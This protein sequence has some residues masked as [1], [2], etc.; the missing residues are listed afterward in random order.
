MHIAVAQC[1]LFRVQQICKLEGKKVWGSRHVN[2]QLLQPCNNMLLLP[3][4]LPLL[5]LLLLQIYKL[6][7]KVW[8]SMHVNTQSL[9]PCNNTLL[10]P[11]VLLFLLLVQIYKFSP[12]G[13]GIAPWLERRTRDWKVAGSNPCW[14]GGRI[15]F[16][17]GQLS[18]LTLILVSVP[19][20][21][22]P[23]SM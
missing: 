22:Y 8:G 12:W 13:A 7:G 9:Q 17:K 4:V 23:S 14:S 15:F 6:K 11:S 20:P 16:S 18:V 21:C 2:A 5:L 3:S 19:P 10:V 1:S